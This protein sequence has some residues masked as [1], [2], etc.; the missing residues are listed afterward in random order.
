MDGALNEENLIVED[1]FFFT[2]QIPNHY[3]IYNKMAEIIG[4][5]PFG[6]NMFFKT[7]NSY[8]FEDID[9]ENVLRLFKAGYK[10]SLVGTKEG[11]NKVHLIDSCDIARF[12]LIEDDD[13]TIPFT[14]QAFDSDG[15][16]V[17]KNMNALADSL[18]PINFPK[19]LMKPPKS[20]KVE[21]RPAPTY[22]GITSA[23]Q[24]KNK[25]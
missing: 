5:I 11:K 24:L 9:M 7:D 15:V 20:T 3:V 18:E 8:N 22:Y 1:A 25:G 12:E 4:T 16:V 17:F 13:F 10:F 19:P 14:N 23:K 6:Y 2:I 21:K